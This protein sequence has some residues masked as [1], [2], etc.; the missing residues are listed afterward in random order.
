MGT[1][2]RFLI[3]SVGSGNFD[4]N[5]KKTAFPN[6]NFRRY[7]FFVGDDLSSR[8][9]QIL[10]PTIQTSPVFDFDSARR[11][12]NRSPTGNFMFAIRAGFISNTQ[13]LPNRAKHV[14]TR[15]DVIVYDN[16][17]KR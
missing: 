4:G 11:A 12:V 13:D 1:F 9:D 6:S 17:E 5:R 2:C 14:E 15:D 8:T 10:I 16:Y 7:P 3:R